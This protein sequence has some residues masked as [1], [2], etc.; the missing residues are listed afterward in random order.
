LFDALRNFLKTDCLRC[1]KSLVDDGEARR[2]KRDMQKQN[3]PASRRMSYEKDSSA[4][5][6]TSVNQGC[7]VD[8][9]RRVWVWTPTSGVQGAVGMKRM[10]PV[11]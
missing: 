5:L 6:W 1:A 8:P 2:C 10:Q 7:I 9:F 3:K 4:V 11:T